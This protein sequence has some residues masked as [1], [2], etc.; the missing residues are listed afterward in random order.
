MRRGNTMV[1]WIYSLTKVLFIFITLLISTSIYSQENIEKPDSIRETTSIPR[2]DVHIGAGWVSG[3]R[4]GMRVLFS[5]N[6]STEFSFGQDI[7][8][9]LG[10]ADRE[11][12][13][14]FGI[15][16]MFLKHQVSQLAC[17]HLTIKGFTKIIDLIIYLSM[18]DF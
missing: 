16:G 14:D 2:F 9:F 6:F 7:R 11:E 12:R 18:L 10:A 13:Y 1:N 17:H 4:I 3:G 8:M 5:E 15:T